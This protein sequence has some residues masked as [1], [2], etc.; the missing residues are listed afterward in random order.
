MSSFECRALCIVINF[1]VLRTIFQTSSLVHFKI[2]PE[3]LTKETAQAFILLMKFLLQS[4]VLRNC[5]VL[6]R[7]SYFFFLHLLDGVCFQYSQVLVVFLFFKCSDSFLF[8]YFYSLGWFSFPTLHYEHGTFLQCQ[9]LFLYPS[10]IFLLLCIRASS[11]FF[12]FHKYLYIILIHK[13]INLFLWFYKF[14]TPQCLSKVCSWVAS[15]L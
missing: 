2:G 5:F 11:F 15:L 14:V 13:V 4:L 3:Y 6:L 12:I 10:C 7:Y 1:L 9:I 8:S